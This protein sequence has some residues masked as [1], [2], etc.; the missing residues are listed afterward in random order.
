[1]PEDYASQYSQKLEQ[2][3]LPWEDMQT[4]SYYLSQAPN[5]MYLSIYMA[6][7]TIL[8]HKLCDTDKA[9]H[10]RELI[11]VKVHIKKSELKLIFPSTSSRKKNSKLKGRKNY[12]DSIRNKWNQ[13]YQTI[14]NINKSK[15]WFF[16]KRKRKTF[17]ALAMNNL[18]TKFT[19]QTQIV[20]KIIKFLILKKR[21][22][23]NI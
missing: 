14:E 8:F 2:F 15:S 19:K 11:Y 17:Y 23:L 21:H 20:T 13:Q 4:V 10:R 3:I 7:C 18:K 22:T 16:V 9:V 6:V 5:S 1:M 12:K